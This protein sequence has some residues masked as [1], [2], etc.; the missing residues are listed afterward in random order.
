MKT[1]MQMPE[2]RES[3]S[4][5]LHEA[6]QLADELFDLQ[7]VGNSLHMESCECVLDH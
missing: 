1:F 4:K 5:L 7:E 2:C 3:L 6:S